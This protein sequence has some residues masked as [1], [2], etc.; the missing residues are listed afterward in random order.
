MP[1][2]VTV[3]SLKGGTG[4]TTIALSLADA[5][6]AAGH[7]VCV[8]D[9]D[10]QGSARV[11]AD[12][13][14]E[15][16]AEGPPVLAL[17]AEALAGQLER[18][19]GA[20]DAVIVDTPPRLD[21]PA[22]V[23]MALAHLVLVPVSPGPAD[24]WALAQT[25]EALEAVRAVRPELAARVVLNR[26]DRRTA[27]SAGL[28]AA[29]AASGMEVLAAGLGQ[30]VAYAEALAAGQGVTSYAPT[31]PAAAEVAELVAEIMESLA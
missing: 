28:A 22:R 1:L 15:L 7:R 10:P 13:A 29:A 25:A 19:G 16:G 9:V 27:L 12:V 21:G 23:A 11:W 30:R 24:V 6:H 26:L 18:E 3:A 4:K 2:V 31:S 20:W 8:V 14:A 17:E 5:L